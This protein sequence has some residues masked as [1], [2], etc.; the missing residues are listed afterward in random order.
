MSKVKLTCDSA[1]RNLDTSRSSLH[2]VCGSWPSS[3]LLWASLSLKYNVIAI[4]SLKV[5]TEQ[6]NFPLAFVLPDG[7]YVLCATQPRTVEV[8]HNTSLKIRTE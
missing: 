2:P 4:T 1:C 5:S 6:D 8:G 3:A 7:Q